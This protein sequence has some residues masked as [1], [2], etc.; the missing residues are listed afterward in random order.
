MK[1]IKEKVYVY[2]LDDKWR[3]DVVKK[4]EN[5]AEWYEAWLYH[6][7]YGVKDMMFGFSCDLEEFE[8]MVAL[9]WRD[10]ARDYDKRYV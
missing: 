10:Y 8:A 9:N 6:A 7:D 4:V 3:C 2:E 5:L 1:R